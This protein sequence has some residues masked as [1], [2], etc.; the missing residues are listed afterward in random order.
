MRSLPLTV[1]SG[2]GARQ[3]LAN[4]QG[5]RSEEDWFAPRVFGA[6]TE[7]LEEASVGD[8]P[9]FLV[10]DSFDP[11]EPWDTV[12]SSGSTATPASSPTPCGPSLPTRSSWKGHQEGK[13]AGEESGY[14]ASTH[15]VAPTVLGSVGIEPSTVQWMGRTSWRWWR[16]EIP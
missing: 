14:Y 9:F 7:L 10:A 8:Q 2:G 11:H 1:A 16:G 4:T 15:D 13:G 3:Y 5:R 12:T 6:A